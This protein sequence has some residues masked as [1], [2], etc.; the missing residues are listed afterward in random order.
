LGA[1]CWGSVREEEV[2]EVFGEDVGGR[3]SKRVRTV[4]RHLIV[5]TDGIDV[6]RGN[7]L[8]VDL[9]VGHHHAE[10]L[11]DAQV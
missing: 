9:L 4:H 7:G 10:G 5:D 3:S 11:L 6:A 2:R 1:T 8:E